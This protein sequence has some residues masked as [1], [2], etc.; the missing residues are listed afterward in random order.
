MLRM[1]L[2]GA[3]TMGQWYAQ[4]FAEYE[5]SELVA[6]CDLRRETA[7]DLARRWGAPAT[8]A[9][10]HEMLAAEDLDAVA[11]ATPDRFHCE[12]VVACL[13]SGKDV[14]CEKPLATTLEDAEAMRHAVE[15]SGR[16]LMVNFGNRRRPRVQ[17]ARKALLEHKVVGEIVNIY[18][19]LNERIGKTAT[20]TWAAETSPVWFLLSHC[21]DTLR[22][23]TG[24]EI[25]EISGYETRK[26]LSGRGISTSDTALFVGALSNGGH[27]FLGSSWVFP[28]AYAPDIDFRLRVLGDSGLFEVQ[29]HPQD[30]VVHGDRTETINYLFPYVDHRG[31]RDN[32]WSQSTR[33]FVHCIIQG[34]HPTPDVDDGMACVKVLL[35]MDETA[36]TGQPVAIE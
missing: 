21:V 6:V 32:W 1:G 31:H 19:E 36:R 5:Q 26:V 8:H 33:Y 25:A 12:P 7:A 4:T 17:A 3:G 29:M 11:V 23:V 34:E 35:A 16:E 15:R 2:I 13:E 28:E 24:L 14:L 27:V 22:Y 10:F 30:M 18:I 9:D 20:L